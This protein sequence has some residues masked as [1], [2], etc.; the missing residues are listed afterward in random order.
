MQV[1][2]AAVHEDDRAHKSVLGRWDMVVAAAV[3]ASAD[4][5]VDGLSTVLRLLYIKDLRELQTT[6][7]RMMVQVQ[8]RTG[9]AVAADS[10]QQTHFTAPRCNM[11]WQQI[12]QE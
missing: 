8:V 2:H 6:I 10:A 9:H 1:L 7:D 11:S 3:D 12:L 5:A 4:A